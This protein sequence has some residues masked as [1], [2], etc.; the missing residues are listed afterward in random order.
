M[1]NVESVLSRPYGRGAAVPGRSD[2]YR[3]SYDIRR[4]APYTFGVL[5]AWHVKNESPLTD[6]ADAICADSVWLAEGVGG[7]IKSDK[8]A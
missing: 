6:L 7:Y 8:N 2:L 4:S 5:L 3:P 1:P